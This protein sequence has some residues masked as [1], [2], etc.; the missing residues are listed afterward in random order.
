MMDGYGSMMG[1]GW[2][3]LFW[4]LLVIDVVLLVVLTIRLVRGGTS[5]PSGDP[6]RYSH[7]PE[8]L[9]ARQ[10]LDQRYARGEID[11]DEYTARLRTL[12]E[13]R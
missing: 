11:T 5:G 3:W 4:A 9:T 7:S 12:D 8:S 2:M 13:G 6:Q 1:W 10:I